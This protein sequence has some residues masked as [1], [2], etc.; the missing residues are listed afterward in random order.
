MLFPR[1]K[2]SPLTKK[3]SLIFNCC[4]RE[5]SFHWYPYHSDWVYVVELMLRNFLSEKLEE[6]LP[7][8]PLA[9]PLIPHLIIDAFLRILELKASSVEGQ[10][11]QQKDT[12]TRKGEK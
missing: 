4:T 6:K 3:E 8:P 9:T 11:L 7:Q 12:R 10:Q 2:S 5:K 1:L